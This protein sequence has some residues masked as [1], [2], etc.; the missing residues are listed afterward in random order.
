M[1]NYTSL[2]FASISAAFLNRDRNAATQT[3]QTAIFELL[4]LFLLPFYEIN[5]IPN[6]WTCCISFDNTPTQFRDVDTPRPV[7]ARPLTGC[8]EMF[9][10]TA[11]YFFPFLSSAKTCSKQATTAIIQIHANIQPADSITISCLL[12]Q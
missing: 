9:P 6:I 8:A 5:A 4:K 1:I 3:R 10:D 2:R 11:Y 7:R 12:R